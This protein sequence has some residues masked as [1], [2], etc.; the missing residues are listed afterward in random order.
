MNTFTASNG[1]KVTPNG[2]GANVYRGIM[3]TPIYPDEMQALRE[4]F[5]A[6][7]DERAGRWRWVEHPDYVVYDTGDRIEVVVLDESTGYMENVWRGKERPG[8]YMHDAAR[9][10]FEAHPDPEEYVIV[11][12]G[13]LALTKPQTFSEA[14]A[15]LKRAWDTGEIFRLVPL[16]VAGEEQ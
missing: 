2:D 1:H 3:S 4:F 6:E 5:Q 16:D 7:A 13:G 8:S 14:Q 12:S 11:W 10:Y 15:E 9:A